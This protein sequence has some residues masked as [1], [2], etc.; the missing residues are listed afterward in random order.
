MSQGPIW[1]CAHHSPARILDPCLEVTLQKLSEGPMW[2][3]LVL[4]NRRGQFVMSDEQTA[5][6]HERLTHLTSE[7]LN[8]NPDRDKPPC[9][10][11]E[12]E[13]CDGFPEDSFSLTHFD[14]ES[15][16]PTQVVS[17]AVS[18]HLYDHR[19][20]NNSQT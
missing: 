8:G 6:I 17:N 11:Q 20:P 9:N 5:L 7:D 13:D 1:R 12:L 4:G 19:F 2:P 10:S 3:E 14:E 16:R 18:L 15:L